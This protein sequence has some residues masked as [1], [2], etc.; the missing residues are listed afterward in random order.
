MDILNFLN[1]YEQNRIAKE[2]L[3]N[4][5]VREEEIS[6]LLE[7]GVIKNTKEDTIYGINQGVLQTLIAK[8]IMKNDK[9]VT[10]DKLIHSGIADGTIRKMIKEGILFTVSRG[11]YSIREQEVEKEQLEQIEEP[12]ESIVEEEIKPVV[13]KEVSVS[14]EVISNATNLSISSDIMKMI[15]E[16]DLASILNTI[17]Q[18]NGEEFIELSKQ[19]WKWVFTNIL[20][21]NQIVVKPV[22]QKK[23]MVKEEVEQALQKVEEKKVSPTSVSKVEK[24]SS[25]IKPKVTV[26]K[27]EKKRTGKSLEELWDLYYKNKT[28]NPVVAREFLEEIEDLSREL[29]IPFDYGEL[30]LID[31]FI[32]AIP[33]PK[34]QLREEKNIRL[35]LNN[36][37]RQSNKTASTIQTIEDLVSQFLDYYQDRGVLGYSYRGRLES[38]KGNYKNAIDFHRKVLE[39]QPWNFT[40]HKDLSYSLFSLGNHSANVT[41]LKDM[42][43]YYPDYIPARLRLARCY[44]ETYSLSKIKEVSNFEITDSNRKDAISYFENIIGMIESKLNSLEKFADISGETTKIKTSQYNELNEMLGNYTEL[45]AQLLDYS[46][47]EE[48]MMEEETVLAPY[49]SEVYYATAT[50]ENGSINPSGLEEHISNLEITTEDELLLYIAAAKVFFINKLPKYGDYYLKKVSR[51][52]EKSDVVKEEY[53]QCVK[54]KML[55][56]NK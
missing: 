53:N 44:L 50:G 5:G 32:C 29:K 11:M 18:T 51:T 22:T 30:S 43:K 16:K 56:L 21:N 12:K 1:N 15:E 36:L 25:T 17:E 54:N 4:Q 48:S 20:Q 7:L 28:S 9:L 27:Q 26:L 47:V 35:E 33:V 13:V 2:V 10:R 6:R 49:E 46:D 34:S 45:Y 3:L 8:S 19:L 23:E 41:V 42:L 52:K 40:A 37:F 55:Y 14:E 39:K 38:L 24:E 31:E